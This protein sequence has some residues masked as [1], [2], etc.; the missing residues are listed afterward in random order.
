V[1]EHVMYISRRSVAAAKVM[2]ALDRAAGRES[3]PDIIAFANA[4]PAPKR[5]THT[6]GVTGPDPVDRPTR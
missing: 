3:A 5:E 2:M 6:T 1:S 4:K